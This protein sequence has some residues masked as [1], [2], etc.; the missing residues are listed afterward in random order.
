MAKREDLKRKLK[1]SDR[2]RQRRLGATTTATNSAP[3]LAATVDVVGMLAGTILRFVESSDGEARDQTVVSAIR[4]CLK[5]T[6]ANSDQVKSL[7]ERLE[8][9]PQLTDVDTRSFRDALRQMQELAS[10]HHD[11]KNANAFVSYLAMLAD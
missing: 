7:R 10:E 4:S 2:R 3:P 8:Q 1:A 9:V 5:G 11:P 6:A